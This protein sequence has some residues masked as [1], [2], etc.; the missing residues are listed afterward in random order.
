MATAR[1]NDAIAAMEAIAVMP[2]QKRTIGPASEEE[3]AERARRGV[4]HR[5]EMLDRALEESF[6]ASDPPAMVGPG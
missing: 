2:D 1:R 6:P 5:E 4:R 3:A